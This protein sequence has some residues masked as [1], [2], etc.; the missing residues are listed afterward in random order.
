MEVLQG[1]N[2]LMDHNHTRLMLMEPSSV[3]SQQGLRGSLF[4]LF[5]QR[6]L[7]VFCQWSNT[8]VA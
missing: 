3:G 1:F 7:H 4:H 5:L 8:L 2:Q 6:S